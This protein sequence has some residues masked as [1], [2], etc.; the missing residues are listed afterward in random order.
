MDDLKGY[1]AQEE[2]KKNMHAWTSTNLKVRK[3]KR[4]KSTCLMCMDPMSP[5]PSSN[6]TKRESQ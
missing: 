5:S 6:S 2:E 3:I 1:H 4:Y